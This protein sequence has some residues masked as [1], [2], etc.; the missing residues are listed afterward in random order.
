MPI[1]LQ[2]LLPRGNFPIGLSRVSGKRPLARCT[3]IPARLKEVQVQNNTVL[4]AVTVLVGVMLKQKSIARLKE[5]GYRWVGTYTE[6]SPGRSL[7]STQ[8]C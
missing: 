8:I 2:G 7:N 3:R 6:S 5:T 4:L 1:C